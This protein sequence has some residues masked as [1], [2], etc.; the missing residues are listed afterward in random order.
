[1]ELSSKPLPLQTSKTGCAIVAVFA[2][3]TFSD[4]YKR[5]DSTSQDTINRLI[6][7]GDFTFKPGQMV[8]IN[9]PAKAAYQRLLLVCL[10]ASASELSL[11]DYTQSLQAVARTL[12]TRP[13]GSA[14]LYLNGIEGLSSHTLGFW[15]AEVFSKQAYRYTTTKKPKDGVHDLKS[16]HLSLPK[17]QN[18]AANQ[19]ILEGEA[20]GHGINL[21]RQLG[22]L[23]GNICT[24]TFLAQEAER[25][26]KTDKK[27]SVKILD[28]KALS[29]LGTGSLL[30]VS[31][32]S[33]EPP[34]LIV[35]EYKGKTSKQP[36]VLVGKGV[37]FDTG[38]ISL[39]PG[40]GM[41]E[42]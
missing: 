28:E 36:H 7:A 24:P 21:A 8:W 33:A 22:N 39:K 35:L 34:R 25:L 12:A 27:F 11:K 29:K 14:I 3:K 10:G 37:T 18:K 23:P 6:K 4:D 5:L 42:M 17:N 31:R 41:D 13:V 40:A 30:S 2:D 26:A 19:G 20:V 9:T 16:L 38:G 1:M 15:A 32:G